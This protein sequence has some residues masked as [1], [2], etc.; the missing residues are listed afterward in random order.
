MAKTKPI[1]ATAAS[2]RPAAAAVGTKLASFETARKNEQRRRTDRTAGDLPGAGHGAARLSGLPVRAG[3]P[4]PR[5]HA[6]QHRRAGRPRPA[7]PP[8]P[9]S[10]P[11]GNQDHVA[12]GTKVPYTEQAAR[13]RSALR[14]PGAVHQALL[15]DGRPA[16]RSRRWCTTS[17]TATPSSGTATPCRPTRSPPWRTPPRPSAPRSTTRTRSSSPR[18]GARPTVRG[19]PEGKNVVMARWTADPNN[20]ADTASQRGVEQAC[21]AVSGQAIADFM[22]KYPSDQLPGAQR[23]LSSAS[24]GSGSSTS[25]R[26]ARASRVRCSRARAVRRP[27]RRVP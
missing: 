2:T 22:A 12:V 19:F 20:P 5:R 23:R 7:A 3:L 9:R 18:P 14:H 17:S 8:R 15:H 16:R 24:N 26:R 25:G 1:K 6:R 10:R 11:P 4:S 13:L 27:R 21:A